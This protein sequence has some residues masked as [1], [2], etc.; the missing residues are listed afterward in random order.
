M[1]TTGN[2]YDMRLICAIGA[3]ATGAFSVYRDF[4]VVDAVNTMQAVRVGCAGNSTNVTLYVN[5]LTPAY[6]T[7]DAQVTISARKNIHA[8]G[9]HSQQQAEDPY[10]M[11]SGY[12]GNALM[13]F[14]Y[15]NE[16]YR[17]R[18]LRGAVN[19]TDSVTGSVFLFNTTDYV[20]PLRETTMPVYDYG[21]QGVNLTY[22]PLLSPLQHPQTDFAASEAGDLPQI[23]ECGVDTQL[24]CPPGR[25]NWDCSFEL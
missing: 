7:I 19:A 5:S 18:L 10:A 13:A 3:Y 9:F 21:L 6:L 4:T 14:D 2:D 20:A 1:S 15:P 8:I 17:D 24:F 22:T 12:V 11:Y 23:V 25:K 16:E